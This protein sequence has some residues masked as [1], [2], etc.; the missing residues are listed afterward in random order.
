MK[1]LLLLTFALVGTLSLRAAT[2]TVDGIEWTYTVKSDGT[3]E[4]YNDYKTSAIPSD[5]SKEVVIPPVINNYT[6]TS[7]GDYAFYGCGSLPSITIPDSV[8]AIS[9]S[10]F[11]GCSNLT[12]KVTDDN[13]SYFAFEG[14]LL[15]KGGTRLVRALGGVSHYEIPD[16]VSIIGE[17]AFAGCSNLKS[18]N[19]P[20]RVT[21]IES[22]AF[23]DCSSLTKITIP[24][25]VTFINAFLFSGCSSLT[26]IVIPDGVISIGIAAFQNCTSLASITLPD[27]VVSIKS[28][29]FWECSSLTSIT[30]PDSV[31]SISYYT[32]YNCSSL[33]KINIPNR[34]TLIEMDT[35]SGCSSLTSITIPDSVTTISHSAFSNCASLKS[36]IFNGRPPQTNNRELNVSTDAK[37]YYSTRYKEEWEAEI[38]DGKWN[39]LA[40]SEASNTTYM[41]DATV[42]G[43]GEVSGTGYVNEGESITLTATPDEGYVF[44]GWSGAVT[45]LIPEITVT[46][47]ADM[48]LIASFVDK[49]LVESYVAANGGISEEELTEK[50]DAAIAEATPTIKTQAI[51]DAI[52]NKEVYYRQDAINEALEKKEVY[53]KDSMKEMAFGAPVMEVKE[54]EVAV[55]ISLETAE[56]LS[57]WSGLDLTGA[58][59]E[60]DATTPGLFR[61]RVPI[62]SNA[63]FYKFVVKDEEKTEE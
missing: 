50:V 4:I 13:P 44:M 3:A 62:K 12:F 33:T 5:I 48:V 11:S 20:N 43:K 39:G 52:T 6:V 7:I 51:A 54:K 29:A 57:S 2:A 19:I 58:T 47:E 49:T 40:M 37:G 1:K 22:S 8:T 41:V 61:V 10:A 30:I 34:V 55:A 36:F 46:P 9:S 42:Y 60:K 53:T 24:D 18:V 32:F 26:S 35:F 27:S 17:S 45:A 14:S 31:T 21:S 16:S 59:L 25:N 38:V 56:D 63:A 15:N 28:S 23:S